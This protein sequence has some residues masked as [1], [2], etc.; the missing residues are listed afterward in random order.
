MSSI[1]GSLAENS[2][3]TCCDICIVE[4]TPELVQG[5]LKPLLH[6][7]SEYT[8]TAALSFDT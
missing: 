7:V 5:L 1:Y 3:K 8:H 4:R 6:E 2:M